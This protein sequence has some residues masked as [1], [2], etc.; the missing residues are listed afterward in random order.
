MWR[1]SS[2]QPMDTM[3]SRSPRAAMESPHCSSACSLKK[4]QLR[5]LPT[6]A[7]LGQSGNL[8]RGDCGGAGR[9]GEL[10]PVGTVLEQCLKDESSAI[11]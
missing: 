10:L 11:D 8:R 5:D 6:G 7:A 3:Q 1:R 2:L 9:L 4:A